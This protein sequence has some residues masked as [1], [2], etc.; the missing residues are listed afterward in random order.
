[1]A[2]RMQRFVIACSEPNMD[3]GG[4]FKPLAEAL[5]SV[6]GGLWPVVGPPT[7]LANIPRVHA[8]FTI[9]LNGT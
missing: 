5:Q 3:T 8:S 7:R 6:N 9:R 1:M 4:E 2:F